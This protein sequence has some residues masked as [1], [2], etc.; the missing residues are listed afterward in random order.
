[1]DHE[2]L[3]QL[4]R[5]HA[6]LKLL[7]ADHLPLIASFFEAAFVRPQRRAIAQHDLASLLGDHLA[8][9]ERSHPGRYPRSA[10]QYLDDWSNA[11]PPYLRKYYAASGDAS[12]YDL[13]P[14]SE[15]A[16]EWLRSIEQRSF[17]GTESRFLVLF[18]QLRQLSVRAS[19]DRAVRMAELEARQEALTL[20][21]ARARAGELDV[22]D[23]TQVRE[24]FFLVEDTARQLLADFRAVEH[25]FRQLDAA[26]RE[27]LA[28]ADLRGAAVGEIFAAT[29]GIWSSD[30]G[31]SFTA[32]WEYLL[33]PARQAEL[34]QLLV[35]CY[36][37]KDVAAL[38]PAPFLKRL[39][40]NLVG[41]A[42]AVYERTRQLVEQL[43]RLVADRQRLEQRKLLERL[44]TLAVRALALKQVAPDARREFH[45]LP[46]V[47]AGIE[48]PLER[49]LATPR[50]V[51]RFLPLQLS[52][53]PLDGVDLEALY[54]HNP[55]HEG[56]RIGWL[57]DALAA[58]SQIGLSAL[59]MRHP[60]TLGL[61]ELVVWLKLA[62][63]VDSRWRTLIEEQTQEALDCGP[64][65][66]TLP[67][68]TFVRA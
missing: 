19:S 40:E 26:A 28:L 8:A 13:T 57:L 33:S 54:A 50:Q 65:R 12:V 32:F 25:N 37:L 48:L 11:E 16:I 35:D 46:G 52:E 21:L 45:A 53:L 43:R 24:R 1:M 41:A 10:R 56:T 64:R 62:T 14:A 18:D 15:K 59:L 6:T 20:E 36:A 30:Q 51:R 31:R 55:V 47:G 67:R 68:I 39:G 58:V 66:F 23:A 9:L 4:R 5:S 7:A 29:D 42:E 61:A 38:A 27:Q 63:S 49:T 3:D 34:D 2:R 22:L 44:R 60:L 17:I